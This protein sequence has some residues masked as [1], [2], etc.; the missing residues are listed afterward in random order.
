MPLMAWVSVPP[1]P[2]QKVFWCS[3]S[4]D[5]LRLERVLAAPQRLEHLDAGLR[6]AAVGEDA[7]HSR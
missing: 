5:P 3:F 1:R 4:R 2:I 6:Q 7:S